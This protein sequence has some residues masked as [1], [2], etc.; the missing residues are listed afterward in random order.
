MLWTVRQVIYMM[1]GELSFKRQIMYWQESQ[2]QEHSLM[3]KSSDKL[4]SKETRM[5]TY[6]GNLNKVG[7]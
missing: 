6:D 5:G 4:N 2:R 7:P 1:S 3:A